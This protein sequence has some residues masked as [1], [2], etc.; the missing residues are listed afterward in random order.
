M[1]SNNKSAMSFGFAGNVRIVAQLACVVYDEENGTVVHGHGAVCLE[2]GKVPAEAAFKQRAL[3]LA[4]KSRDL[5]SRRLQTIMVDLSEISGGPM[6]VD[7]SSRRL[8]PDN[9]PPPAQRRY[10][11]K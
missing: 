3:E 11:H 5:G 10:R 1:E 4:R 9:S 6:R 8:I 7:L 2:G